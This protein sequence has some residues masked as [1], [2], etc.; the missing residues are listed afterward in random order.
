MNVGLRGGGRSGRGA[1]G[2]AGLGG[3]GGI[4]QGGGGGGGMLL[5]AG[6]PERGAMRDGGHGGGHHGGHHGFRGRGRGFGFP[7]SLSYGFNASC[8]YYDPFEGWIYVCPRTQ[9]VYPLRTLLF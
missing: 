2:P 3:L 9:L 1:Q 5:H 8:W 7:V 4:A 6:T